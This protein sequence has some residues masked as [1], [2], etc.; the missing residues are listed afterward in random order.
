MFDEEDLR[1]YVARW[2]ARHARDWH[3]LSTDDIVDE[4]ARDADFATIRLAGLLRSPDGQLIRGVVATALPYPLRASAEVL[5]EAIEVAGTKR[6]RRER[7]QAA[8]AGVLVTLLIF[9]LAR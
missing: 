3:R 4:L 7:L 1:N 5:S 9:G 8:G 2:A 6:T